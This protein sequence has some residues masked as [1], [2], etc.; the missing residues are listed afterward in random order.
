M[1]VPLTVGAAKV[2]ASPQGRRAIIGS[3]IAGFMSLLLMMTMFGGAG[4]DASASTPVGC[5]GDPP[6]EPPISAPPVGPIQPITGPTSPAPARG[7][8][9]APWKSWMPKQVGP[10][11]KTQIANAAQVVK[12]AMDTHLDDWGTSVA[13]MTAMGESSLRVLTHGDQAGP[14]S[15]GLFQQRSH[16]WGSRADR[17]NPYISAT[18]FEKALLKVPGY[19]DLPPTI[20]AHRTQHNADANYYTPF[21]PDA[22]KM[23]ATLLKDPGLIKQLPPTGG[24][25]DDC[26]N[27]PVTASHGWRNPLSP[28]KYTITSPFGWRNNPGQGGARL[29]HYGVDLAVPVGTKIHSACTGVVVQQMNLPKWGGNETWVNCGGQPAVYAAY[30]HQSKFKAQIGQHVKVGQVIG[31][32]GGAAGAPGAGDSVGPHLHFQIQIGTPGDAG[33]AGAVDPVKFLAKKG[34]KL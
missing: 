3:A 6:R 16:G 9:D 13:V 14:D 23:V 17:L 20:A 33:V 11:G 34:I 18:N 28:T 12:A 25:P 19:H 2:A 26:G 15:L 29:K 10:Y 30:M 31:L 8:G 5:G 24:V 4:G 22:V 32:T 1:P 21:W 7:T 27:G